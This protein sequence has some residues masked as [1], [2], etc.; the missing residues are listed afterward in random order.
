[1]TSQSPGWIVVLPELDHVPLQEPLLETV[2]VAALMLPSLQDQ[3]KS[4]F[5]IH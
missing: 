3:D 1:M 5:D 2:L 4:F